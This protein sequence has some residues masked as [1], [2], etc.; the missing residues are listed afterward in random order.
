M[1]ATVYIDIMQEIL[2]SYENHNIVPL[3]CKVITLKKLMGA[4]IMTL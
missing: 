4:D 1:Y 2:K 3:F